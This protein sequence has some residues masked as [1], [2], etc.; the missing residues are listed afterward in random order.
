MI[1]IHE[2]VIAQ[3][4]NRGRNTVR[5]GTGAF[6]C[7]GDVGRASGVNGSH[8]ATRRRTK[9]EQRQL[10]SEATVPM[11]QPALR[12]PLQWQQQQPQTVGAHVL[13]WHEGDL[14]RGA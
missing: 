4:F 14:R 13:L 5:I 1:A 10:P 12:H 11:P 3:L 6:I 9:L 8:T 2:G 7:G